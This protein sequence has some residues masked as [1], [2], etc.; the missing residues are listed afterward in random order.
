VSKVCW[1]GDET[2]IEEA[3]VGLNHSKTQVKKC[4]LTKKQ[5]LKVIK[6]KS[7]LEIPEALFNRFEAFPEFGDCDDTPIVIE[8]S[9]KFLALSKPSYI[10][11]HPLSYFEKDNLIS[12]LKHTSRGLFLRPNAGIT[13]D[14]GL[15]YRLDY[16][17]S[18]LVLFTSEVELLSQL[19]S[20]EVAPELK[21]YQ[22][23][24]E[25]EYQG[26]SSLVHKL[27]GS[28]SKVFFDEQGKDAHITVEKKSYNNELDMTLLEVT[29]EEGLRH[30]IRA[31]LSLAGYPIVG[32]VLYGAKASELGFGLHC[33]QYKIDSK[34]FEDNSF[35]F[36]KIFI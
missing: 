26:A 34:L 14:R 31:Q 19:R 5:R 32:D 20:G 10:H 15:L 16:E 21:I 30:Q 3:L 2:S 25:G 29:L 1:I 17:T 8:E 12:F 11:S 13:Y 28:G 18:G 6:K 23:V 22:A 33:F 9:P 24:V 7:I 35:K 4:G 36:I 27:T